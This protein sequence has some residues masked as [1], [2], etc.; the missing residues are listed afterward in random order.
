MT[1]GT[2]LTVLHGTGATRVGRV[3]LSYR[4]FSPISDAEPFGAGAH[5]CL[6][7]QV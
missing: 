3:R 2:F 5:P 1:A 6:P 4:P 7:E